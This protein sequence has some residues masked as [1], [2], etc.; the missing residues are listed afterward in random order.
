MKERGKVLKVKNPD[1]PIVTN[2]QQVISLV[3]IYVKIDDLL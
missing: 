2:R 3:G 1:L